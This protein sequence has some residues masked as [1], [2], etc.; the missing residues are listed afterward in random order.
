MCI[1]CCLSVIGDDNDDDNVDGESYADDDDV[2]DVDDEIV[3]QKPA[4]ILAEANFIRRKNRGRGEGGFHNRK[5]VSCVRLRAHAIR[6][7]SCVCTHLY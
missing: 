3:F 5:I 2:A 7:S 1:W 6:A 4:A